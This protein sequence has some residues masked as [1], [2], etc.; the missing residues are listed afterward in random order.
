MPKKMRFTAFGNLIALL[1]FALLRPLPALATNTPALLCDDAARIASAETGV[2][3][4]IMKAIAR[5]ETGRQVSGVLQ[6]WPWALN[7]EGRGVWLSTKQEAMSYLRDSFLKGK[8][9]LD[10]G[11]YQINQKW[12][13]SH[14]SSFDE[15]LDPEA[16]ALYAARFLQRLFQEHGT[17]TRAAGAYH[18]RTPQFADRYIERFGA[19]LARLDARLPAVPDQTPQKSRE[20]GFPLLIETAANSRRGSLFPSSARSRGNLLIRPGVSN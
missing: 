13:G 7:I 1:L 4:N 11:C 3:L 19:I 6:P 14:F 10:V 15:M 20:N 12:H 5:T 18:S 16:N 9:N 8:Q 2:P 17:W